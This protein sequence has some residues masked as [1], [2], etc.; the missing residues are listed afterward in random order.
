MSIVL[1]ILTAIALFCVLD[2]LCVVLAVLILFAC[3]RRM[4]KEH[5]HSWQALSRSGGDVRAMP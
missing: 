2:V 1:S 3:L 4:V 5:H